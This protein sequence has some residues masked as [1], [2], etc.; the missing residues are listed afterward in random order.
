M[1]A[2]DDPKGMTIPELEAAI[3][4]NDMLYDSYHRMAN[5]HKEALVACI[6]ELNERIG[7]GHA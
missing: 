2:S 6:D 3:K 1:R 4:R 7:E 5:K